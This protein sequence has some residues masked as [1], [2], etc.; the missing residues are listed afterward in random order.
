M[1][2]VIPRIGFS[3]KTLFIGLIIALIASNLLIILSDIES[4]EFFS[5]RIIIISSIIAT[6]FA[7]F[8]LY[9]QRYHHGSLPKA[10]VALALALLLSL[11]AEIIWIIY[12]VVLDIVPPIPSLA[13]IVSLSSYT[14]LSYYVFSTYFRFR[15]VFHFDSKQAIMVVVASGIFLSYVLYETVDIANFSSSRGIAIFSI[16]VAYPILD[17]III[18]PSFLIILNYRKE[19]LW[20][21]PWI[22]KC[23]GIFLIAISDSWFALFIITSMTTELWPSA[24]IIT[25]HN[26]ILAG[27]LLWYIKFLVKYKDVEDALS[28]SK[29]NNDDHNKEK[30]THQ[31]QTSD[32]NH[33]SRI[34]KSLTSQPLLKTIA[35]LSI[36]TTAII[37]I[38]ATVS[39]F[40][41]SSLLF[42]FLSSFDPD[43]I[44]MTTQISN[45]K[46]S[47]KIGALLPLTGVASSTGKS[48]EEALRIALEDVNGY[49]SDNNSSLQYQLLIEDTESTP[50]KSLEKLKKLDERYGVNVVIGPAT[51]AELQAVEEYANENDILVLSHSSTAPSLARE[52]DNVFRFVPD[53]THQAN[54]MTELMWNDEIR[55]VVPFWRNDVYGNELMNITRADFQSRGGIFYNDSLGYE[56]KT[57]ELA[58]SLQRINFVM[59]DKDLRNLDDSV[60]QLVTTHG[61]NKVG[62]YFISLDEVS[63]IFIQAHSY[64]SLSKVKWYGSDGSVLNE[65][66]IRNHDSAHFA[67]NTSFY[68]PI[69]SINLEENER[70]NYLEELLHNET[71]V[72][73][74]PYSAVAYDVLWIIALAKNQ[75]NYLLSTLSFDLFSN[76]TDKKM[77]QYL[78][79]ALMKVANSYEGVTGNTTLNVNGDRREGNYDFWAVKRVENDEREIYDWEKMTDLS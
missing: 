1:A 70:L 63:P 60:Q 4:R 45:S 28:Q 38:I 3:R 59:W 27:G 47:I 14:L 39:F 25:S 24:L 61:A 37:A 51:S 21:T 43:T 65:K 48:T 79:Q 5:L 68:N 16:L 49:F 19:P 26:L 31:K 22:C 74:S 76:D 54:V 12:E 15:K 78:K 62:V 36:L 2:G 18:V 17:S 73:P 20:F 8:I 41:D 35:G 42:S 71:G 46:N 11:C 50:S 23:A 53:D 72:E 52:G 58:A 67:V 56:P 29:E 75:T 64:P 34:S 6:S 9:R 66:L 33:S 30:M 13:D 7:I 57:G 32:K 69:Y 55:V 77:L 44:E 10:D 40:Q